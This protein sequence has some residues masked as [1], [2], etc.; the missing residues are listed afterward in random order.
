M[1]VFFQSAL[2]PSFKEG[3]SLAIQWWRLR[4]PRKGAHVWSGVGGRRSPCL[5]AKTQNITQVRHCNKFSKDF[6]NGL[7]QENLFQNHKQTKTLFSWLYNTLLS[8]WPRD[9]IHLELGITCFTNCFYSYNLWC[10]L[11]SGSLSFALHCLL[12]AGSRKW[13]TDILVTTKGCSCFLQVILTSPTFGLHKGSGCSAVLT[14]LHLF[15]SYFANALG[16]TCTL[17]FWSA[18]PISQVEILSIYLLI[19]LFSF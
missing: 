10:H 12:R 13:D 7:H 5:V 9:V 8:G 4:L 3:C 2:W 19:A 18:F 16:K 15:Q 6:R 14:G 17:Q 1:S 11:P